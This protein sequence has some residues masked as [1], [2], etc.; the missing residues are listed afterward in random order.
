VSQYYVPF[1]SGM[2]IFVRSDNADDADDGAEGVVLEDARERRGATS[3]SASANDGGT[4]TAAAAAAA[5]ATT[6]TTTAMTA[7]ARPKPKLIF[8]FFEKASPYT[9]AALSETMEGILSERPELGTMTSEDLAPS[10]WMSVAWYPI[11]RIPQGTML[12]DVQGCFLTYHALYV[13]D[14]RDGDIACPLPPKMSDL[15]EDF[16][17]KRV[18]SAREREELLTNSTTSTT[19]A[20]TVRVLRPF[21]L[22]MYK[23]QGDIWAADDRTTEWMN[24]LM[25][26]AYTWLRMRKTVHPDYEFFS[27]FG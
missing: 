21:G 15:Q 7:T 11:Y 16:I 26:G 6:T 1:L 20:T 13:G 14:L 22:S 19:S 3:A 24:K 10:S 23:M 8:E 12:H 27:H 4:S 2:Q 5:A 18:A 17:E 25:D 9:R